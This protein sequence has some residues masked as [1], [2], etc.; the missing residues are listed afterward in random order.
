M[1]VSRRPDVRGPLR[2][3]GDDA[4]RRRAIGRADAG[5]HA[6][7]RAGIHAHGER[8]AHRVGI[9]A[10]L[11]GEP[12]RLHARRFERDANHPLRAEHDVDHV[13][14]HQLGRANE[15]ALVL[16]GFVVGYDHE[17]PVP[18]VLNRLFYG[19]ECHDES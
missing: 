13:G 9:L 18:E 1:D 11:Q 19:P 17:L 16:A 14:R 10:R 5:G 12:E 4:N 7:L 6:V 2:R 8:G 3:I 15:V